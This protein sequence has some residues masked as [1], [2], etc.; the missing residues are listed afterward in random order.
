MQQ[1]MG[2]MRWCEEAGTPRL[3]TSDYRLSVLLSAPSNSGGMPV[4][5]ADGGLA[6]GAAR[7][8]LAPATAQRIVTIASDGDEGIK[9]L[10][11]CQAYVRAIRN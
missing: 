9:A 5:T 4:T 2:A 10:Q 6:H 8:E 1:A 11:A 3:A 7:G